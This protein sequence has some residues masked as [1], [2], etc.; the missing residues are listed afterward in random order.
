MPSWAQYLDAARR[1]VAIARYNAEMLQ[2]VLS[3]DDASDR[4]MPT[5]AVQAHFEGVVV[6]VMAA[7]DQVAQAINSGLA[8]GLHQDKLVDGAFQKIAMVL[9]ELGTWFNDP[10]GRRKAMRGRLNRLARYTRD[11]ES[12]LPMLMQRLFTVKGSRTYCRHSE[13]TF[14][15]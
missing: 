4:S 12:Y 7:V 6:A 10:L 3:I 13:N 15:A 2:K 14:R 5:I 11:R 1:K 9:P 8:L